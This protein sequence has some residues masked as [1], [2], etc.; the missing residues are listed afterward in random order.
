M[1]AHTACV[2]SDVREGKGVGEG[3]I[4]IPSNSHIQATNTLFSRER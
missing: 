2:M 3:R 1:Y 4:I